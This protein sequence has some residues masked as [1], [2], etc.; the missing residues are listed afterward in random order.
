MSQS[1]IMSRSLANTIAECQLI[2]RA[3]FTLDLLSHFSN[4]TDRDILLDCMDNP[5]TV[6]LLEQAAGDLSK[7]A[8][9]L[10]RSYTASQSQLANPLQA[11]GLA[12]LEVWVCPF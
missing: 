10:S 6:Q 8:H 3:K 5:S 1:E 2:Q 7:F 11:A 12:N 4:K 9:T